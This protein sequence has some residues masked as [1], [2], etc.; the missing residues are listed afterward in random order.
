MSAPFVI[1]AIKNMNVG[2]IGVDIYPRE[3]IATSKDVDFFHEVPRVS[4]SKQYKNKIL[5][6]CRSYKIKMII[7]LT[8]VEVDYYSNNQEVFESEGIVVGISK[9]NIVKFLR[10]K[11]KVFETFRESQINVIP[12]Y[13]KNAYVE[14][15]N[16]YPCVAKKIN[17]RSSEGLFVFGDA[18][19][20]DL[21]GLR[22]K[23]YIFQPLIKG[24][25]IT[26]DIL[27]GSDQ[28]V[29]SIARR[30]LTRTKN[31]AGIAVEIIQSEG[32][33]NVIRYFCDNVDFEG[34]I[35][36]E[37]IKQGSVYYMMDINPRFS[38]GVVYSNIAGYNFVKNHILYFR[39]KKIE[40]LKSVKHGMIIT[41]K[42]V[43]VI[44]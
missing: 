20:L 12:T 26:I 14:H 10:N 29:V 16:I 40:R 17:G 27:K 22:H 34:C 35:N 11:L 33:Q 5:E 21:S 30:E 7:P 43:E 18:N 24:D 32:L 23:K 28:E 44:V 3:W 1:K 19:D 9:K 36:I 42:Y 2:V 38:A 31:G 15:C 25:I 37:F 8:D 39:G 41:R 6:L 13:T 4:A